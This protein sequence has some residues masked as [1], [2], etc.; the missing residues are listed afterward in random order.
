MS[1]PFIPNR[2]AA[3]NDFVRNFRA[4]VVAAPGDYGLSPQDA[5]E[6]ATAADAWAAAWTK[7]STRGSRTHIDVH[8]KKQE[9]RACTAVLRRLAALVRAN[10]AIPAARLVNLGVIPTPRAFPRRRPVE[11]RPQLFLMGD[12]SI[13]HTV[14]VVRT[15][16]TGRAKPEGALGLLLCRTVGQGVAQSPA[17]A[18]PVTVMTLTRTTVD[19]PAAPP[20]NRTTYF[21]RWIGPRGTLGPW[22]E[23]L[24]ASVRVQ[25]ARRSHEVPLA[26]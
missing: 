10:T 6:L 1:A 25:R 19:A 23:P 5:I 22:S 14:R 4:L 21:A 15:P 8:R 7:A 13:Q 9:R 3:F 24:S 18:E 11:E 16:G 12:D 26:A 20:G 17:G 2:D